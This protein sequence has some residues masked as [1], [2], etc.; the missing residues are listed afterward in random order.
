[1]RKRGIS[2]GTGKKFTREERAK[3]DAKKN[4]QKHFLLRVF[5]RAFASSR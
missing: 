5:L 4:T 2:A 1:M 3:E